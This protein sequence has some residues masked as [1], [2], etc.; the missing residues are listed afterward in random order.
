[1]VNGNNDI[2]MAEGIDNRDCFIVFKKITLIKLMK[3][4]EIC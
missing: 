1:M 4:L 2:S 3:R